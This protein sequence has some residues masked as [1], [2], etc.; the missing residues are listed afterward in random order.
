MYGAAIHPEQYSNTLSEDQLKKLHKSIH[1]V[2]SI[3]VETLADSSRFP[4]DW[5]EKYRW[6]KGKKGDANRLPNGAKIEFVTVGGRTSA[7]VPSIQKKTGPVAGD[8][9]TPAD[10]EKS[11]EIAVGEPADLSDEAEV[12][13]KAKSGKRKRASKEGERTS[14][15]TPKYVNDSKTTINSRGKTTNQEPAG[16]GTEL[17]KSSE[18]KRKASPTGQI[19]GDAPKEAK[20]KKA[21]PATTDESNE[22]SSGR[23]RSARVSGRD[24]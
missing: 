23:R 16:D 7:V 20:T 17:S 24:V 11:D 4:E 14:P 12:A 13:T 8:V 6:G 9:K 18:K 19:N 2:C 5:L 10:E 3:A 1:Y 22:A 15:V 21:K